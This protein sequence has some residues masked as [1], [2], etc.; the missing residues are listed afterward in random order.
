MT[1][2]H[3]TRVLRNVFHGD[4]R[5][6]TSRYFEVSR[7]LASGNNVTVLQIFISCFT[8]RHTF[9]FQTLLYIFDMFGVF[10]EEIQH[11]LNTD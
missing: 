4:R 11:R 8:D 1:H 5:G 10:T 9:N 7:R 2:E 6:Y 3:P